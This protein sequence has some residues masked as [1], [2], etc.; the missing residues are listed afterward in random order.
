MAIFDSEKRPRGLRVPSLTAMKSSA[1]TKSQFSFHSKKSTESVPADDS[2]PKS[3][4]PIPPPAKLAPPPDKE[5]PSPPKEVL[6]APKVNPYFPPIPSPRDGV[7]ERRPIERVPV[8]APTSAPSPVS[9]SQPRTTGMRSQQPKPQPQLQPDPNT[10]QQAPAPA[11]VPAP[12][13]I[14]AQA[15]PVTLSPPESLPAQEE[16]TSPAL[17]DFIP[18]PDST[19]PPLDVPAMPQRDLAPSPFV[20]PEV[21]PLA[22]KLNMVHFQCFQEHRNMPVAQNVW[23]PLP[24]FACQKFDIEIRHRCVFC[25]LRVCEGCYQTLQKCKNRSLE[26]LLERVA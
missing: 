26:V 13:L 4:Q 12:E 22:P 11:P 5:L 23:C 15:P 21:E 17:E 14:Q 10:F 1:A 24:C 9:P 19:E 25:C 16:A 20:P 2:T 7:P 18:T 6:Q 8:P 3:A